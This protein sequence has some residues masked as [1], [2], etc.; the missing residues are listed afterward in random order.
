MHAKLADN[1]EQCGADLDVFG[2]HCVV[3]CTGGHLFTRHT[4]V[5]HICVEAGRAAGYTALIE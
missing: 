3:C 4:A 1:T 5:N 2:D